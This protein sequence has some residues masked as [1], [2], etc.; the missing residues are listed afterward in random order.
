MTSSSEIR[1]RRLPWTSQFSRFLCRFPLWRS[2]RDVPLGRTNLLGGPTTPARV[3]TNFVPSGLHCQLVGQL[4]YSRLRRTPR[5]AAQTSLLGPNN[6]RVDFS[7]VRACGAHDLLLNIGWFADASGQKSDVLAGSFASK[8][9]KGNWGRYGLYGTLPEAFL[10]SGNYRIRR[11][12]IFIS[13]NSMETVFC[14][15][16]GNEFSFPGNKNSFPGYCTAWPCLTTRFFQYLQ[17]TGC[18]RRWCSMH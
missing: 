12:R 3:R 6:L 11:K 18:H 10:V 8:K 17:A 1:P 4:F 9:M 16:L 5:C 2:G 13:Y 15:L 14:F 7:F